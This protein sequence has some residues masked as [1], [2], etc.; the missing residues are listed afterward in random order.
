MKIMNTPRLKLTA[1]AI[2]VTAFRSVVYLA[3][4]WRAKILDGCS[5]VSLSR[6]QLF[7]RSHTLCLAVAAMATPYSLKS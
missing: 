5:L 1:L 6:T 3:V 2:A 4:F 7:Q